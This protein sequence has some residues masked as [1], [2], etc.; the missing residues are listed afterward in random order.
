MAKKIKILFCIFLFGLSVRCSAQLP[1]EVRDAVE[2]YLENIETEADFTQWIEEL[3]AYLDKP[4]NLNQATLDELLRFPLITPTQAVA[5]VDHRIKYG[6]F[7]HLHELQVLSFSAE[8]IRAISEFVSLEKSAQQHFQDLKHQIK[9]GEV[10]AISTVKLKYPVQNTDTFL[11]NNSSQNLRFRYSI[12]GLYSI[13]ISAD[14]DPGEAYWNKG[15][16][17]FSFHASVQNIGKINA[18]VI[19]DYLLGFGQGLV[20]GSGVGMGKSAMVMQVKRNAQNL[21]PYRGINEFLFHRGAAVSMQFGRINT[22]FAYARNSLDTRL[23]IDSNL[24]SSSAFQSIDLDGWHRNAAEL[25]QKGNAKR[26][27][28]GT[29][30]QYQGKK[31]YWGA[32]GNYYHFDREVAPYDDLYRKFY[33]HGNSLAFAHLFQAHTLGKFHIFSEWAFCP[34]NRTKAG[35]AGLLT[36]LGRYAEASLVWRHYDPGFVSP[37]STA[38][39]NS[40]QNETGFYTGIKI[41]FSPKWWLS[42]YTDLWTNPWLGYRTYAPSRGRDMLWQLDMVPIR[43]G[44]LY[45]RFR[46]Q[47]RPQNL[48]G[49]APMKQITQN[50]I[51]SLR[52]HFSCPVSKNIS[53]QLRAE[54]SLS[55][56]VGQQWSSSLMFAQISNNMN[57]GKTKFTCRYTVFDVPYYYNRIFAYESQLQNDFGTVAFYGKGY[58]CYALLQQKITRHWKAG[59]RYSLMRYMAPEQEQITEKQGIFLQLVY[60]H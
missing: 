34:T 51:Q 55:E 31:G 19:G 45:L 48:T 12:P 2:K 37:F 4:I 1:D 14:K 16:D 50:Q 18:A 24:F 42:H 52:L 32:G 43:K 22:T 25:S 41:H 44:Q 58:S 15:P 9:I 35:T 39:G 30:L 40:N 54:N 36:T 29:W 3:T 10:Q 60:Q 23:G 8:Q 21:R 38:F 6:L 33:S 59:F 53:L 26:Q 17:F 47:D 20:M 56:I 5:I 46:L 11:G 13:G 7:L 49:S 57:A 27:M 28:A